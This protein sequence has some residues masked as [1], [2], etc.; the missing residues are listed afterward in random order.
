VYLFN[1]LPEAGLHQVLLNLEKSL[2]Q[3]VRPLYVLYQNPLLDH[4]LEGSTSLKSMG[5]TDQ[6]SIHTNAE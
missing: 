5:G 1:P 4:V 3:H 2:R 6:Y